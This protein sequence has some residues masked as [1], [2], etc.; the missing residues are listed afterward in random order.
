[1]ATHEALLVGVRK[2][3]DIEG[4]DQAPHGAN[5]SWDGKAHESAGY[6]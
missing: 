5:G 4:H 6:P 1:M 3:E 2:A